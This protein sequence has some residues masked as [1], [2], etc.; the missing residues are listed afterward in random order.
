LYQSTQPAAAYSM[1]ARG[2]YGPRWKTVVS[3]HSVLY[4]PITKV[5][6][7][8]LLAGD[9]PAFLGLYTEDVLLEDSGDAAVIAEQRT[10]AR[11]ASPCPIARSSSV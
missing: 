7:Q 10:V 8:A 9:F 1:S 11:D 5:H 3:M 6:S 2:L 4:S